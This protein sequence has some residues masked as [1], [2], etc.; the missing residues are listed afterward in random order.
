MSALEI[1][2]IVG[3]ICFALSGFLISV[4]YKLD[5]LGVFISSF[6]AM[7]FNPLN[8]IFGFANF[9]T[10]FLYFLQCRKST[11]LCGFYY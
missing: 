7:F 9:N 8:F 1:A 2:D 6:F 10:D 3:I 11:Y 4:H 5:I